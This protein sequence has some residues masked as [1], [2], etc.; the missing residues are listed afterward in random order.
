M[1]ATRAIFV[2]EV[3]NHLPLSLSL[4]VSLRGSNNFSTRDQVESERKVKM[5]EQEEERGYRFSWT[6]MNR[7]A[8]L[9]DRVFRKIK[10][11]L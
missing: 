6:K 9:F 10:R 2:N 5:N 4:S 1:V 11:R 7:N 3:R 8:V